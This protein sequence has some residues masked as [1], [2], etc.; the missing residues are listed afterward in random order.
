M[1]R[2]SW[3][4]CGSKTAAKPG[5][6]RT[7]L[8]RVD[9][10]LAVDHDQVRALVHLVVLQRLAGGQLDRDRARLSAR[11]VQ[12]LRLMRLDV[13]RAQVPVLHGRGRTP[14]AAVTRVAPSSAAS[15]R[16]AIACRIRR[17]T[18]ICE[19]PTR[20]PISDWVRS[21]AKRSRSTSRS[22]SDSTRISRSTVAASSA[23]AEAGVLAAERVGDALALLVVVARAVER[24]GAVGAGGLARL[25][26]LLGA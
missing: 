24:D 17:E 12:D 14:A 1:A 25:E 16:R 7:A 22:R 23:S 11:G 10:D 20:S 15:R 6:P 3:R 19:T 21:S 8:A 4:S 26:H 2:T 13:E 9:L 5:P 18:C